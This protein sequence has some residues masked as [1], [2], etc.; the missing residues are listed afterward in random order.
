MSDGHV[1]QGECYCADRV[2]A[3]SEFFYWPER[4]GWIFADSPLRHLTRGANY[5]KEERHVD[6]HS[7]EPFVW[8]SCPW[9]GADLPTWKVDYQADG[10][11]TDGG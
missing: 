7:G 1:I 6:D 2:A 11:G 5:W 8:T 10:G 9:C 4:E 3:V